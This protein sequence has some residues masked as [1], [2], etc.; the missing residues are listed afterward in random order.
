[1]ARESSKP[2]RRRQKERARGFPHP[3]PPKHPAYPSGAVAGRYGGVAA[4]AGGV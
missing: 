4:F 1:M 2:P 3:Y